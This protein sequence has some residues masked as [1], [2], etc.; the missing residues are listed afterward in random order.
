MVEAETFRWSP[1]GDS[2]ARQRLA[3]SR[4]RVLRGP[5]ATLAA[6]RTQGVRR[7]LKFNPEIE[8]I[9]RADTVLLVEGC[10]DAPRGKARR[11]HRGPRMGMRTRTLQEP[12]RSRRL[13]SKAPAGAAGGNV[14]RP[15]AAAPRG[16]RSEQASARV[17]PPSEGNEARRDGRREVGAPHGTEEAGEPRGTLWRDGGAGTRNRWRERWRGN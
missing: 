9:V 6:K 10:T 7:P 2:P 17:V 5:R 14:S 15:R 3:T 4:Y 11:S 1:A 8:L 12:G 16:S 13:Y